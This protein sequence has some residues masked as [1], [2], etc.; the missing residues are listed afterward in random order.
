MQNPLCIQ[1]YIF[2]NGQVLKQA[3]KLSDF[4]L[5]QLPFLCKEAWIW[6]PAMQMPFL[7][8]LIFLAGWQRGKTLFLLLNHSPVSDLEEA[9]NISGHLF[10]HV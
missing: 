9:P 1:L 5:F 4:W 2:Q 3:E 7:F 6:S 8:M 10:I